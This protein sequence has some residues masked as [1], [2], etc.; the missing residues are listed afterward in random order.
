M[1]GDDKQFDKNYQGLLA[2]IEWQFKERGQFNLVGESAAYFLMKSKQYF[3][4][5]R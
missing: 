4:A 1:S 2:H 3:S 5:R